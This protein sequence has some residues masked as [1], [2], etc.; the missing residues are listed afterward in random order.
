M[1]QVILTGTLWCLSIFCLTAQS[2]GDYQSRLDSALALINQQNATQALE[3]LNPL[4][5][6]ELPPIRLKALRLAAQAHMA[7]KNN[8]TARKMLEEALQLSQTIYDRTEQAHCLYLLGRMEALA[9]NF[10]PAREKARQASYIARSIPDPGLEFRINNL[11]SWAFFSTNADF[12]RVLEHEA[13]QL[14]L[15]QGRSDQDKA[16]VYNNLGYDLTVAGTVPLDSTIHLMTFANNTYAELEQTQGRWYTLMNLTWQH[17]LK[18]DLETSKS[19]GEKCYAQ[20]LHEEDRHAVVEAAFQLGETLMAMGRVAEAKPYYETGLKWRGDQEDRDSYVFDVYYARYLWETGQRAAAIE[21]LE[22]AID[23]LESSEVF[24]EMHGRALL[25]GYYLTTGKGSAAEAQLSAIEQP[26]HN[27]IAMETRCLAA[28]TRAKVL[29]Q[30]GRKPEARALME[31]W[32]THAGQIGA[33]Q[34]VQM[35]REGLADLG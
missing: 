35:I 24:Y 27:Y 22:K 15:V 32:L 29:S 17:R 3:M 31:S 23:F 16:F 2:S 7:I 8:E 30:Q 4:T 13:R 33:D 14:A 19:Y 21:R 28:L 10:E 34:L 18:N 26:R 12:N 20:A 25:A 9:G 1:K 6:L 11:L 5:K